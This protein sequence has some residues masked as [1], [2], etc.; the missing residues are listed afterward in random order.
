MDDVGLH[1]VEVVEVGAESEELVD[2][3]IE[4]VLFV[5]AGE[6]GISIGSDDE[7]EVIG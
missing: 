2:V 4:R 5:D 6:G 1:G 3:E 7:E